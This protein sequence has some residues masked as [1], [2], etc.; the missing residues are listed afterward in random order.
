ME[1]TV[2]LTENQMNEE[3]HFCG[4]CILTKKTNQPQILANR[5]E[6]IIEIHRKENS[7]YPI[8]NI[9]NKNIKIPTISISK[10]L[11][12]KSDFPNWHGM[13]HK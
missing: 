10:Q 11:F 7:S 1:R 8:M 5:D 9:N 12:P 2:F 13:Y 3:N 6:V 4:K